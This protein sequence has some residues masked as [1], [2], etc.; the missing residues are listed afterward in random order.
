MISPFNELFFYCLASVN[1]AIDLEWHSM[2]INMVLDNTGVCFRAKLIKCLSIDCISF[3]LKSQL[4]LTFESHSKW[5]FQ[6]VLTSQ[7][8]QI[9]TM[10]S[11]L[12]KYFFFLNKAIV[13]DISTNPQLNLS[14]IKY[15]SRLENE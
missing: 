14:F 6:Q 9:N 3:L 1:W 13:Y 11:L 7:Y 8:K 4:N 2:K 10:L 5:S 12:M 15:L